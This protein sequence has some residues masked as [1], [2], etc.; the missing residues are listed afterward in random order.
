MKKY[1]PQQ[2][3][4]V[5]M[6]LSPTKGYEQS[7]KRPC[8]IVTPSVYNKIGLCL[9]CPITSHIKG[10]AGEISLEEIP[11][12]SGVILTDHLRSVDWKTREVEFITSTS[13]PFQQLVY[14]R[15]HALIQVIQ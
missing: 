7:G 11:K 14:S 2:G 15:L 6:N 8:Y 9:L 12:V 3:D 1:L 5:W 10:Y 13:T 4:I